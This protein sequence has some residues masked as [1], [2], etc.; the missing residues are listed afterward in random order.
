VRSLEANTRLAATAA[1][2]LA[3]LAL[4][5]TSVATA[6]AGSGGLSGAPEPSPEEVPISEAAPRPWSSG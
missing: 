4:S 6:Q 5:F 3:L 2:V 1:I